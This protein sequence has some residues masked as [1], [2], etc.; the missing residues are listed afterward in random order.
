MCSKYERTVNTSLF[1]AK[2]VDGGSGVLSRAF[3][4]TKDKKSIGCQL[5]CVLEI[6][7]IN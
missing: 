6:P 1:V 7:V 2:L 4:I 5:K 3:I